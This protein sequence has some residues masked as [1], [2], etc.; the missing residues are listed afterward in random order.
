M[1]FGLFVFTCFIALG[2]RDFVTLPPLILIGVWPV[3]G[4]GYLMVRNLDSLRPRGLE[5]EDAVREVTKDSLIGLLMATSLLLPLTMHLAV[6]LPLGTS[7]QDFMIWV[8]LSTVLT[9]LAHIVLAVQV[10]LFAQKAGTP[11]F[12]PETIRTEP[13]RAYR[14]VILASLLPGGILYLIPPILVAITGLF[15][16]ILFQRLGK[17]VF[18][19]ELALDDLRRERTRLRLKRAPLEV[20]KNGRDCEVRTVLDM[21]VM[22]ADVHDVD[23][24]APLLTRADPIAILAVRALDL[25][26]RE[27]H[28]ALAEAVPACSEPVRQTIVQVFGPHPDPKIIVALH[29]IHAGEFNDEPDTRKIAG[30]VVQ[31]IRRPFVFHHSGRISFAEPTPQGEVSLANSRGE[32]SLANRGDF[33]VV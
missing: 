23:L 16:P 20:L 33:D 6:V 27:G 30:D 12:N 13:W 3:M 5:P 11:L 21:A 26:G 24:L 19:E 25:C 29:R 28:L 18:E 17:L 14:N 10:W 7:R 9:G 31:K 2:S 22:A 1:G 32:V 8:L 4:L 15:I